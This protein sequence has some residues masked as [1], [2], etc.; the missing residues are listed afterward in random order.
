MLTDLTVYS[1]V[2]LSGKSVFHLDNF[3]P[4]LFFGTLIIVGYSSVI[5]TIYEISTGVKFIGDRTDILRPS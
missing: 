4:I 2:K 3:I 1:W 5:L